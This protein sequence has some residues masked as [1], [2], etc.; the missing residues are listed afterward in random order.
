MQIL[1]ITFPTIWRCAGDF[2]KEFLKFKM[3]AFINFCGR[4]NPKI[5]VGNNSHFTIRL[6]YPPSENN[7]VYCF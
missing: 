5:E 1:H 4:K 6:Q 3:A 2:L 7:S